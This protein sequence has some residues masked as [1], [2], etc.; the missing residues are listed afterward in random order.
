MN[1]YRSNYWTDHFNRGVGLVQQ[2]V[3]QRAFH[4]VWVLMAVFILARWV[5]GA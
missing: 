4:V 3:R 2:A 5:F 1:R